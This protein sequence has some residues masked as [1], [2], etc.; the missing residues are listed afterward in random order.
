MYWIIFSESIFG[1]QDLHVQLYY[2]AGKLTT[3]LGMKYK[4]K[5]EA[6][7]YDG[8]AVLFDK[9]VLSYSSKPIDWLYYNWC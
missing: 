9:Q 4:R 8:A 2:T 3:Y 7:K 5:I 1:Y 6:R